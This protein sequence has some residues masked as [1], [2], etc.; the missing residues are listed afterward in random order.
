[1]EVV[2]MAEKQTYREL[3]RQYSLQKT[4]RFELKPVGKTSE[5]L[6]KE[7]VFAIDKNRK[8]AYEGTKP[9]FDRLHREFIEESL[10]GVKLTGLGEYAELLKQLKKDKNNKKLSKTVDDNKKDLRQQITRFFNAKG[11]EWATLEYTHLKIKKEDLDILFEEQVFGILK[12]RYGGEPETELTDEETGEIISIFDNWKGFTGYFKKFFET[13]KNLYKDDGKAGAFATRAIDQNLDRFLGNIETFE[14]NRDR[15]DLSEVEKYFK[16]RV[17][18]I[19]SPIFYNQCLLQNGINKYNDFLGGKTLENGKKIRGVNEI[20]NEY[21]QNHPEEKLQFLKKLDKQIL[22]E[23]EKFTRE[24]EDDNALFQE[25]R[26]FYKLS[27]QKIN[28]LK[29]LLLNFFEEPDQYDLYGVFIAKAGLN[30]ITRRWLNDP[31]TFNNSLF[32]ILKKHKLVSAKKKT[33]DSFS[34]L[35]NFIPLI[36]IK[37]TLLENSLS[38]SDK[39]WK[40]RY[41]S[42][43]SILDNSKTTWVEFLKIFQFEFLS[44][45]ERTIKD[46]ETNARHSE[47][48]DRYKESFLEQLKDF[49]INKGSKEI[50]KNFADEV[51][52]IYQLAKYFA[53]EKKRNWDVD[54]DG[55]LSEF[56]TDPDKGYLLFYNEAYESIVQPYN[57]I[58]N[59]LTKKPYNEAKWKLNLK[60]SYLLSGWSSDFDTYSS[61][62]IEKDGQYYLGIVNGRSL[63]LTDKNK[64]SQNITQNNKA[65]K[66]VYDFQ[67]PDNKNTPRLFIRSKGEN[68]SPSVQELNLPIDSIIGIY[69]KGLFR[70]ENR[71]NPEF[72]ESLSKMIEYF[73]IG[74]TKHESYR[75]FNF[76]WKRSFDYND[77][78]EFYEDTMRSCYKLEWEDINFESLIELTGDGR[79]FL[80]KIHS[81]DFSTRSTGA[82]NLHS[83]Y[84]KTLFDKKNIDNKQGPIFKLS[85]GGEIFFRPKTPRDKLRQGK[86]RSGR[87]IIHK[88]RYSEDKIFFHFPIDLNYSTS[89]RGGYNNRLN[90]LLANNP[91]INIIG[92]DRG[93]KHLIYYSVINQQGEVLKDANG[94]LL[95]GSL[96]IINDV[97]YNEKLSE[98]AKNRE[99][100]RKDW[101]DVENIKDLKKGYISQAVRAIA[102]LAITHNAIIVM[103]D[104]NMRFKQIRGGIEK[105]VYQQLEKALIN[106]LSFL[107]DKKESDP[108][109]SGHLLRAYQLTAPFESFEKIGKQTGIIFYTQASYTSKIDPL[110]GWRPN[111]RLQYTNAQKAKADILKFDKI[112]YDTRNDRFNFVYNLKKFNNAKEF[113]KKIEWVI[114]SNVER[115]RWDRKEHKYLHYKDLTANF[116]ELFERHNID[117]AKNI[118]SQIGNTEAKGNERFFKD[119]VYYFNLVCQIRNT[120]EDKHGDDNDF[121]LSPAEPNFDS[122]RAEDFGEGLPKNG[123]DNGAYNIARKGIIILNKISNFNKDGS[124]EKI[125]WKDLFVSG[126]DWDNFVTK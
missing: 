70:T 109:K 19:F 13:R 105:S 100:S 5:L 77:I 24:I 41:Y 65:K 90:S 91:D 92:L 76:K 4:L 67:K 14:I 74:F 122:R 62:I 99:Q 35:P 46:S 78:A 84:F 61:L 32:E 48:Y 10:D 33:D 56:Y 39:I 30:T 20:I 40:D 59:Y 8:K 107:V 50:I 121:I 80:F 29:N 82:D 88:K 86:D 102:D 96:N 64:I 11:E 6:E 103:E 16:I 114:N 34:S 95:S 93:E 72:K 73:K 17:D 15:I 79:L 126:T 28:V 51:L 27:S 55:Q 60:C 115:F 42:D 47:G 89:I 53:L 75:N 21:R 111:I 119:F 44:L 124:I 104:L 58:R 117:S 125:T 71:G 37:E 87:M 22:S 69:D 31:E 45:F 108:E 38:V 85:G 18:E 97:N 106:K 57:R 98:K 23:K 123:D 68:F 26:E 52:S 2:K 63:S 116:K 83:M 25:L 43:L 113:P 66:L 54:Y 94:K 112:E 101:Q 9:F 81:K 110:T 7:N 49:K 1:M 120:Q 3:T 118:L 36:Y 12:D